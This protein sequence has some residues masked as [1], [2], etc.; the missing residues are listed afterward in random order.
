MLTVSPALEGLS[1]EDHEFRARLGSQKEDLVLT[2]LPK[3]K[4]KVKQRESTA[5]NRDVS[6]GIALALQVGGLKFDLQ[7]SCK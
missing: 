3:P 1:Q 6:E 2:T 7:N 4:T 5:G